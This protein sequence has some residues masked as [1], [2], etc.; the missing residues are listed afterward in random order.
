[1]KRFL[2]PASAL[3]LVVTACGAGA[4]PAPRV[5]Q[6]SARQ[7]S[8]R[9]L[10]AERRRAALRE[11]RELGRAFVPLPGA[12]RDPARRDHVGI[13]RR[14]GREPVG[15]DVDAV[16]FWRVQ[17]PLAAVVALVRAHDPHG[18]GLLESSYG[19]QRPGTVRYLVRTLVSPPSRSR[20]ASRYLDET[21]VGL[22]GRTVI[23]VDARVSWIYP[24]SPR[25]KV[26]AGTR[27][28]VI[29]TPR[30]TRTVKSPAK[31]ASIVRWFDALPVFPPGIA[32]ACPLILAAQIRLSFRSAEGARLAQATVPATSAGICDPIGFRVGGKAERPL[33]DSAV[34][35]SFARRLQRLLGVHLVRS[36]R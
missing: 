25:E 13:L 14:G 34:G 35:P 15:E 8:V 6:A 26:P 5:T 16:R 20:R 29:H 33:I 22:P 1:M 32:V 19:R 21:I 7:P 11:A 28:I 2:L 31:V 36:S 18:F 24:R 27:E 17:K 9:A 3:V 23:R 12:R 4:K 10:A 30:T